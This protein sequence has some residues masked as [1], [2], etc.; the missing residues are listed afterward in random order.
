MSL[1]FQRIVLPAVMFT[2]AGEN[3]ERLME[4]PFVAAEPMGAKTSVASRETSMRSDSA[5]GVIVPLL[6]GRQAP[7]REVL[8]NA[9]RRFTLRLRSGLV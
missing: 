1:F 7:R 5:H 2:V 4:T 3:D 8:P 9:Y 6:E